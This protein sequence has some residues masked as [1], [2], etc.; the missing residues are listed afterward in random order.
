MVDVSPVDPGACTAPEVTPSVSDIG[1]RATGGGKMTS[2]S[3]GTGVSIRG[4]VCRGANVSRI[5]L[6]RS[7]AARF[8]LSAS[9]FPGESSATTVSSVATAACE[10]DGPEHG[11]N[12]CTS[13][14]KNDF[15][16]PLVLDDPVFLVIVEDG[17]PLVAVPLAPAG[18]RLED[19]APLDIP[20]AGRVAAER[21]CLEPRRGST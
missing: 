15:V 8:S 21:V 3:S 13:F 20:A 5:G 11:T 7:R 6:F 14:E 9:E 12:T 10:C 17:W 19:G 4:G 18:L 1:K 16:L 2:A